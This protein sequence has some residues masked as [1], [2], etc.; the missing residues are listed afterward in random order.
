MVQVTA[1]PLRREI[2]G[3]TGRRRVREVWAAVPAAL[4]LVAGCGGTRLCEGVEGRLTRVCWCGE[5]FAK[6][7]VWLGSCKLMRV[8]AKC[9][10][11]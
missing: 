7:L 6:A 8:V 9:T 3:G 2:P 5:L 4:G 10:V 11:L 1:E